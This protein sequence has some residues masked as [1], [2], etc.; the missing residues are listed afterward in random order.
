VPGHS[1]GGLALRHLAELH[2]RVPHLGQDFLSACEPKPGKA[3]PMRL[4]LIGP[5]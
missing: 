5:G 3:V 2:E 4:T 1:A